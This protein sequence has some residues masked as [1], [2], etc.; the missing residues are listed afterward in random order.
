MKIG[1]FGI[2]LGVLGDVDAMVRAARHA[3]SAGLESLWTGEHVVLPDPRVPPSPSPPQTPFLDPA[4]A[5]AHLAAVTER[6]LLGT[7]II[8]L[9]Q[10]NPLVL[11]K[12]LTSVDV[13]SKG[14]L[15][16]GLG[17]GYLEPEFRAL[18]APFEARGAV[19]DECI[20][21]LRALWA[22]E[23][24]AY[25]GEFFAFDG[26]DAQP[27]PV[28]KPHPPIVIGGMSRRAAARAALRGNG[29][30]GF[31]T[32]I[33]ATR[34]SLGWIEESLGERDPSLGEL[35]I[36]VSPPPPV[37]AE[38]VAAYAEIG[39]HRLIPVPAAR[40]LDEMLA[41]IDEIAALTS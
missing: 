19:T 23:K 6:V 1:L 3:E 30:Y 32:D 38:T 26:I 17:A 33:D 40:S 34:R 11:A 9:P 37:T 36:S 18:G 25:A 31:M 39:V 4:V 7:G 20:D 21:V 15:V 27:R 24:P 29:W 16:F 10:R 28:Q 8:I 5:L 12:E 22:Q 14:R 41:A 35:E 2:N 13:V